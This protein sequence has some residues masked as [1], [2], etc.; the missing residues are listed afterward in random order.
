LCDNRIEN[1][2]EES[3]A[4]TGSRY[5]PFQYGGRYGYYTD[6][7]LAGLILAKHRW[8]SPELLRWVSRDPIGYAG[9]DNLYAYVMGNPVKYVDLDGL[10][11]TDVIDPIFFVNSAWEYYTINKARKAADKARKARKGSKGRPR[12]GG[13]LDS[14]DQP[15]AREKSRRFRSTDDPEQQLEEIRRAQKNYRKGKRSKPI[16]SIQKSTDRAKHARN[17]KYIGHE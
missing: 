11:P 17:R 12:D 10:N 14:C 6:P 15:P 2:I 13:G 9:G 16:D 1:R 7:N 3:C 8:Y 4:T 5:T